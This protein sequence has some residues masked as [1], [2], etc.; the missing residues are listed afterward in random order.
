MRLQSLIARDM[1]SQTM[2][3]LPEIKLFIV[4]VPCR[5]MRLAEFLF[6]CHPHRVWTTHINMMINQIAPRILEDG[7]DGERTLLGCN[8]HMDLQ[9]R[10]T[11]CRGFDLVHKGSFFT[12]TDD[13]VE[14]NVAVEWIQF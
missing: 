13:V 10:V 4:N 5:N 11:F 2:Q 9:A 12:V 7:L 3:L 6:E 8:A 14:V 1:L